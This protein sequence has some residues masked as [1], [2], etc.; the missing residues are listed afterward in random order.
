MFDV[1]TDLNWLAIIVATLAYFILGALWFTP[2]FGAAY[3]RALDA[4][5][6]KGQKWP[7]IYY[8]GPFLSAL[9]TTITTAVLVYA[10]TISSVS[11]AVWLGLI[12]GVGIAFS[13]SCNNAINP[14]TP[15][16]LL[17][18]TVTGGYHVVGITIV[19]ILLFL[20]K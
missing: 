17:Y 5:R 14:K 20:M 10:L 13:V 9:V 16:P 15:R 19:A 7:A 4:K 1:A 2:L 8:I 12:L 6:S 18:G 3:D 11:E